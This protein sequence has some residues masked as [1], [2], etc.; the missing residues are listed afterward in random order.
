MALELKDADIGVLLKDP[1]FAAFFLLGV[2][3]DIHQRVRLRTMW[4]TPEVH[5][6]SG[7]YTGK[8]IVGVI[9]AILRCALLPSPKGFEPRIVGWFCQDITSAKTTFKKEMDQFIAKCPRL[10]QELLRFRG[11]A[12]YGYRPV[13][14]GFEYVFK[15]GN[16]IY[17]PA[18]GMSQ[19][20]AKLA[21]LRVH[22]GV[23]EESKKI[24][25][26]SEALDEQVLS[27]INAEC[28]NPDHPL[29]GNHTVHMGHAEDPA[30]HPSYKRHKVSKA[31]IRDGDQSVAII[32]ACFRDWTPPFHKF[33]KDKEIRTARLSMSP[34][35]FAQRYGGIWEY[36]TEDWYDAKVM[37]KCRT[38]LAP[39]LDRRDAD[40]S[41]FALGWDTALGASSRSDWS[42]GVI[43]RASPVIGQVHDTTHVCIIGDRLWRISPVWGRQIRRGRDGGQL[44]GMIHRLDQR[45]QL[46]RIV[47]DPGGGG[48]VLPKELWKTKQFFDDKFHNVSG[49]CEPADSGLYPQASPIL[50]KWGK[51][52]TDLAHAFEEPKYMATDDGVVQG[53]Q[54]EAQGL[55]ASNSIMWPLFP[56]EMSKAQLATLDVEQLKSLADLSITVGQFLNIKVQMVTKD[57]EQKPRVNKSGFFS[58]DARGKKDLAYA[59]LMGLAGLLSLLRDPE[60]QP[61]TKEESGCMA[62]G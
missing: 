3:L 26:K 8:T 43:W 59:A 45:F 10:R 50:I 19:D 9:W 40:S 21:S 28:W 30:T 17:A 25:E 54:L 37:E 11:G 47:Y 20:A 48:L 51:G 62:I 6:D 32:T 22:D 41:I 57:G 13:E 12:G 1:V 2:E 61:E 53:I 4:F 46:G 60:F 58:F 5:D 44:A 24:D 27:R 39:V 7:I 52:S 56:E 49:I 14:S 16:K 36:G 35:K 38:P 18:I 15:N 31:K 33:R 55:F 34:A 23:I 42:A 29:W